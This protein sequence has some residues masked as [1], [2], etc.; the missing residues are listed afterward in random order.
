MEKPNRGGDWAR[1]RTL[2]RLRLALC[3][4]ALLLCGCIGVS[5]VT[6]MP[7]IKP[8]GAPESGLPTAA[9]VAVT[10]HEQEATPEATVLPE[11][12]E[13][14]PG[15]PKDENSEADSDSEQSDA[16]GGAQGNTVQNVAIDIPAAPE[17]EAVIDEGFDNQPEPQSP[18]AWALPVLVISAVLLAADLVGIAVCS[19]AIRRL[20]SRLRQRPETTGQKVEDVDTVTHTLCR[21]TGMAG[22]SVTVG[23]L[24]NIGARPSQ[25]DSSGVVNL[26]DGVLA[27]VA[28]GMGGLSDGDKVSQ[29]IVYTMLEYS[30][31]LRPGQMDGALE[32]M[33]GGVNA[34]INQTFGQGGP[35]KCGSTLLAVLVRQNRFHWIAVGDSHIYLYHEGSLVQLNQEHNRG[36]E[37]LRQAIAGQLTF[38]A[39][40]AD[41][42]KSGLTSFLGMG[43]LKYVEK[44]LYSIPLV[45]GDRIVLMTDGVFNALSDE[46]IRSVLSKTPD[47]AEAARVLEQGVLAR[48]ASRQD[49]FTAVILGI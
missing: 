17:T 48:A 43:R 37:L 47:V 22:A 3:V 21:A 24:H 34:V 18:P 44:S 4:I 31:A 26:S 14:L 45:P 35:N 29:K 41:P 25:Q 27:V 2:G 9:T 19:A 38:D 11:K 15:A 28:D 23:Q 30:R 32:Q 7:W 1:L 40:R 42:K 6:L 5:A 20:Q 10:E 16:D 46:T 39:V 13:Y 33:L 8:K 36:Q 49:N 12:P